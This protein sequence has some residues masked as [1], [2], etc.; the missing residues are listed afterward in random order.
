MTTKC[1]VNESKL[2]WLTDGISDIL[3]C[4]VSQG[5]MAKYFNNGF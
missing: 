4:N 5:Q 3:V 1:S 2:E